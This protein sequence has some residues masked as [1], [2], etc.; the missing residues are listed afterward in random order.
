MSEEIFSLKQIEYETVQIEGQMKIL[1]FLCLVS[2]VLFVNGCGPQGE[3]GVQAPKLRI[4]EWV[5][6]NPVVIV[7]EKI[8]VMEFWATWCPPC[9]ESIPHLTQLQ[10]EYKN[11]VIFI[12]IRQE[13][14]TIVRPFVEQMGNTMN[15]IVAVDDHGSTTR[16]YMMP[17]KV[18][19]IPH[20]FVIKDGKIVW[21]GHPMDG[22]DEFL[23]EAVSG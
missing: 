23:N 18:R 9:R 10:K 15:Y 20:A 7:P 8:Y 5:K 13:D 16:E 6:G 12:G 19:G 11:D 14:S 21:H 2:V 4:A 17:F 3:L 1:R 22:L